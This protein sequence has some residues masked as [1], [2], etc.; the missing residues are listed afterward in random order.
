MTSRVELQISRL[1]PTT[2]NSIQINHWLFQTMLDGKSLNY[3]TNSSSQALPLYRSMGMIYTS[4]I[5]MITELKEYRLSA[6]HSFCKLHMQTVQNL[7][8][9]FRTNSLPLFRKFCFI[10]LQQFH[11]S[12]SSTFQLVPFLKKLQCQEIRMFEISE[13]CILARLL[14]Q[15]VA[16]MTDLIKQLMVTSDP[17]LNKFRI[18]LKVNSSKSNSQD[19]LDLILQ[20]PDIPID[21]DDFAWIALFFICWSG[22]R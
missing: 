19:M 6:L 2:V 3:F 18:C 16:N 8:S 11:I 10:H 4:S 20:D 17:Y 21:I 5:L 14:E 12:I 15:P 1:I 13:T 7:N 9:S 22:F